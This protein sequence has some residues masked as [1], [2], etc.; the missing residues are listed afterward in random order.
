ML[1]LYQLRI[2][3]TVAEEGS[4]TRAAERLFLTQ[5]A[6]SQHIRTLEKQIGTQ[7][8]ERGRRGMRLTPAGEV[9]VEYAQR[10]LR[11]TIEAQQAALVA[12]QK[13]FGDFQLGAS[14]GVG[15]CLAPRWIHRLHEQYPDMRV[16]LRTDKTP[17][18]IRELVRGDI[19]IA[20]VEGEI[21][22]GPFFVTPLWDEEIVL[23]VGPEHPWWGRDKVDPRELHDQGFIMREPESLTRAWEVQTLS[24]YGVHAHP[25]AEL[26]SPS[27]IKRAVQSGLGIALL[28]QFAIQQEINEG[29]L[30]P[31]RL[32]TGPLS[33]T[34][35]L[36]WTDESLHNSAVMAFI[37][38]LSAEFPHLTV[39]MRSQ[40]NRYTLSK[41]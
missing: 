12:S 23:V 7:L 15:A 20:I 25:V 26:D 1:T 21:E 33:R 13:I 6:V 18:V 9:L 36:A 30:H 10:I 40:K 35:K 22:I 24:K 28:P 34:L 8:F 4:L 19:D 39:Q 3:L 16:R 27:A 29:R 31:V 37:R 38:V 11:L 5:P 41:N 32:T 17:V 2:F 14:P